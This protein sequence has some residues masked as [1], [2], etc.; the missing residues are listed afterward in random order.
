MINYSVYLVYLKQTDALRKADKTL[1]KLSLANI[2]L[3]V[4]ASFFDT[5]LPMNLIFNVCITFQ[6]NQQP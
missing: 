4:V 6:F 2:K 1:I 3:I 5:E